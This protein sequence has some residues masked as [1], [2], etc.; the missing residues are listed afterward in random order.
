MAALPREARRAGRCTESK[1]GLGPLEKLD[2]WFATRRVRDTKLDLWFA[3][4]RVSAE[5]AV[6]TP[7]RRARNKLAARTS[8]RRARNAGR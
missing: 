3:T 8:A 7:A 5:L 2:S 1:R 4:R 6:R